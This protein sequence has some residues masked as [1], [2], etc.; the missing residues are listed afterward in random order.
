MPSLS[1]AA[2][3]DDSP[4]NGI[5]NPFTNNIYVRKSYYTK[6]LT[7]EEKGEL[8]QVIAHEALHVFLDDQISFAD[9]MQYDLALGC[10]DWIHNTAAAIASYYS[11]GLPPGVNPPSV[12]TYPVPPFNVND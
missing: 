1:P 5:T 11:L 2:W 9:Y 7:D 12:F 8:V 3:L 10:H 4:Y 6:F